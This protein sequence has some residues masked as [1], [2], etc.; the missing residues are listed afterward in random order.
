M[1]IQSRTTPHITILFETA[2]TIAVVSTIF[3]DYNVGNG[4]C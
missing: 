2:G 4:L 1:N 3:I